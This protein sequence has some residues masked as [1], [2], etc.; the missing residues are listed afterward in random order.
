MVQPIPVPRDQAGRWEESLPHRIRKISERAKIIRFGTVHEA[1]PSPWQWL[2]GMF[3]LD[4]SVSV[5]EMLEVRGFGE[6]ENSDR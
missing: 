5:E 6:C 2:A 4:R 1:A 3:H